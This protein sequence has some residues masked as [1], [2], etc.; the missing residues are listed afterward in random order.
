M[1]TGD[2]GAMR[3]TLP[4]HVNTHHRTKTHAPPHARPNIFIP[5]SIH[6]NLSLS[7]SKV[8]V[9]T[10]AVDLVILDHF[11]EEHLIELT[12]LSERHALSR[13]PDVVELDAYEEFCV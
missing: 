8:A 6:S 2:S 3:G 1:V 12:F 5:V 4:E 13:H 11:L 9:L 7:C 10:Q